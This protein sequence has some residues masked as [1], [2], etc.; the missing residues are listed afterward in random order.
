MTEITPKQVEQADGLELCR[1]VELL[2]FGDDL[3]AS[4]DK[5]NDRLVKAI[6]SRS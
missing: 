3:T 2:V 1:F 6:A 4:T 5:M